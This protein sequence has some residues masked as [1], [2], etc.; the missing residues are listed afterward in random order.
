MMTFDVDT[1]N[2]ILENLTELDILDDP[3]AV[4]QHLEQEGV[5]VC[6]TF[7][8]CCQQVPENYILYKDGNVFVTSEGRVNSKLSLRANRFHRLLRNNF[9]VQTRQ[10]QGVVLCM[11][12]KNTLV[13]E[14]DAELAR[15]LLETGQFSVAY[16]GRSGGWLI[17]HKY[18]GRLIKFDG[19]VDC[20]VDTTLLLYG[21]GGFDREAADVITDLQSIVDQVRKFR[22]F[23]K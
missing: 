12:C 1:L 10:G 5:E 8:D 17:L 4:R 6:Y 20:P 13:D 9:S 7:Q 3:E 15:E 2:T 16:T 18:Q 14:E 19:D 11:N 23:S 21:I 22:G